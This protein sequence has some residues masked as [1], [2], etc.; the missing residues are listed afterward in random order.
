MTN[1]IAQIRRK[2]DYVG[3]AAGVS[4]GIICSI[5]SPT[6]NTLW[7]VCASVVAGIVGN[8]LSYDVD[9]PGI[10][11]RAGIRAGILTAIV[12]GATAVLFLT[13]PSRQAALTFLLP[14][15]LAT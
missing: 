5:A 10:R 13:F 4:A 15:L 1:P 9:E 2:S 11:P 14:S 8:L 6:P 7:L 12:A 3:L